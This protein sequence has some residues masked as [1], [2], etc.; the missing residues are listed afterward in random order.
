MLSSQPTT[1]TFQFRH[2]AALCS[3]R[4]FELFALP[5]LDS[6]L[7]IS[8]VWIYQIIRGYIQLES[9]HKLDSVEVVSS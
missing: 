3:L 2:P 6:G 4:Y 7:D 9:D 5:S 1:K 8:G